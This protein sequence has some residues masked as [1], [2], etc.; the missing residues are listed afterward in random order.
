[1]GEGQ[2]LVERQ[3][4]GQSDRRL[5]D[6]RTDEERQIVLQRLP[7]DRVAAERAKVVSTDEPDVGDIEA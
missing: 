1:V 3:R 7:E 2:V 4:Q 6:D 5:Q